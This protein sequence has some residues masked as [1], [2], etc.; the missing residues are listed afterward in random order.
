MNDSAEQRDFDITLITVSHSFSSI[1]RDTLRVLNY[2][3]LPLWHSVQ[4]GFL[5]RVQTFLKKVRHICS[6]RPSRTAIGVP[7]E[8]YSYRRLEV[9]YP[10]DVRGRWG[11]LLLLFEGTVGPAVSKLMLNGSHLH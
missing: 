1:S 9:G 10:Q 6:I 3:C 2:F 4:Q 7:C 8:H 11:Q 5:F